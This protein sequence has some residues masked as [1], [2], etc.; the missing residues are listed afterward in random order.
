MQ[1]TS[2]ESFLNDETK[3]EKL[4][5]E[6]A[7]LS[8]QLRETKSQNALVSSLNFNNDLLREL[9][10]IS[11]LK[12]KTYPQRLKQYCL[13]IYLIG[14]RLLYEFLAKNM[15][16]P[17]ISTVLKFL[18][19]QED[20]EFREGVLK[21]TELLQ[22]LMKNNYPLVGFVSED[23][24]KITTSLKY[25]T[26]SNNIVG[27]V[28][29]LSEETGMPMTEGLAFESLQIAYNA[30]HK[31]DHA[32]YVNIFMYQPLAQNAVP[33]CMLMYGSNNKYTNAHALN[34]WRYILN[35]LEYVGIEML[36]K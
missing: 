2:I 7:E 29:P 28:A 30:V 5:K 31:L 21:S 3:L 22:Y 19:S 35:A 32:E 14:G 20:L 15:G 17:S 18:A 26:K 4:V 36:G 23:Q 13:Y 9:Y 25:C 33:F 1:Q 16:L 24:T 27:L 12:K 8:K 34:R 11:K 6:R 10:E